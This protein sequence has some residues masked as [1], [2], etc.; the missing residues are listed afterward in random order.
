MRTRKLEDFASLCHGAGAEIIV[1]LKID[2][3][4][5]TQFYFV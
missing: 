2:N 5:Q 1:L 3:K 4:M